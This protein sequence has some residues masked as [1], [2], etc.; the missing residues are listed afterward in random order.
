MPLSAITIREFRR[1]RTMTHRWVILLLPTGTLNP[2]ALTP[3]NGQ[4][5]YLNGIEPAGVNGFPRGI[6]QNNY[7]TWQPR[8]GFAYDVTGD[9][10]T[11]IR[12]GFGMFFERVQGNDVYNAALN[13]PFAYQPSA[14]N[15]YFSNPNTSA[16]T[17]ATTSQ[18]FPSSFTNLE[19]KYTPPGRRSSALEFNG[20]SRH[21][22]S[23][24]C[25]MLALQVGT[26]TMTGRSTLCL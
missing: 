3:S 14:T 16:L 13:P 12:G 24:W 19:Y 2:A 17:G 4:S 5:F 20:S 21:R 22:S 26:R 7:N 9:G 11:V 18:T 10:K 6:V 25:S 1:R 15:V 23:Q 8:V